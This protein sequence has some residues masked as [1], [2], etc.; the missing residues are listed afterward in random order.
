M[1]NK[2]N[3]GKIYVV[4]GPSGSGKTT[5]LKI[6]RLKGEFRNS[7]VKIIT[8]TTRKPRSGERSGRDYRFVETAEFMKR[9][10]NA[11][12]VESE[13]IYG[14]YYAVPRADLYKAIESGKDALLCVDVKGALSIK[15]VFPEESVLVFIS[16]PNLKSLNERLRLRSTEHKESLEE[17][18]RVSKQEMGH[19]KHYDYLVV[20]DI[21]S[22]AVNKLSAIIIAERLRMSTKDTT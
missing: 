9:L 12:F 15:R 7:L 2:K 11:E 13:E 19:I 1:P 17:R 3:S 22:R 16:P 4:S 20:N 21:L 8:V 18:L 5:I 10:H 14:N 6:L